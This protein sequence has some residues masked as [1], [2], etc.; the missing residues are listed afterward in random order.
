MDKPDR[1]KVFHTLPMSIDRHPYLDWCEDLRLKRYLYRLITDDT[2]PPTVTAIA[3]TIVAKL[4]RL[5]P[6]RGDYS[7]LDRDL[8]GCVTALLAGILLSRKRGNWIKADIFEK[9]QRYGSTLELKDIYAIGLQILS[10]PRWLV[11][12]FA[13][14]PKLV[15]LDLLRA[16]SQTKFQRSLVDG[17]R[18]LPGLKHF[19]RTNLGMLVRTSTGRVKAALIAGGER[20]E[21][22]ETMLLLHQYLT[23]TV[24]AKK[25][26]TKNPQPAH[27][28]ELL[29]RYT[30]QVG[31]SHPIPDLDKLKELLT[32]MGNTLRNYEQP[33]LDSI[34]RPVGSGDN[35]R[36]F[37]VGDSIATS[38]DTEQIP[39]EL[40]SVETFVERQNLRQQV[41]ELLSQ[42][43]GER[44]RM[45]MFLYGLALKQVPAGLEL[46]CNPCNISRRRSRLS[47]ELAQQLWQQLA[48]GE[49]TAELLATL[50][51]SIEDICEDYYAE[52]LV[53]M[54]TEIDLTSS[55]E[56]CKE[57]IDRVQIRWQFTFHPDR[58]GA[59]AAE[60]FVRLRWHLL[61]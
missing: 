46:G 2:V 41:V 14:D 55:G 44:E 30:T 34:D 45:L 6:T 32:A 56:I 59:I 5:P 20:G 8:C 9:L 12:G 52:L 49:L 24:K 25:F 42:L 13:P 47:L 37:R 18:K 21:R 3:Q 50:V 43:S 35:D 16:Y 7:Q 10:D 48:Q 15:W 17:I 60:K 53:G 19:K 29:A 31:E 51:K 57:F 58:Q 11:R 4:E 54:L 40:S 33:Q 61:V 23:E 36:A 38:P 27:D 22:L 26:E 1:L 39:N 28:R